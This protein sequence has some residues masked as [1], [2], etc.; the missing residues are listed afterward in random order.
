ME[1]IENYYK[2]PTKITLSQAFQSKV[3]KIYE[4]MGPT[5]NFQNQ[6]E[7]TLYNN[8]PIPLIII[9][10]DNNGN[11]SL[12]DPIL[13][14]KTSGSHIKGLQNAAK[15][16]LCISASAA[17]IE[18]MWSKGGKIITQERSNLS[19]NCV[20]SLLY[21]IGNSDLLPVIANKLGYPIFK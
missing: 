6:T 3:L 16:Y 13:W 19:C 20:S 21:V 12:N 1:F 9:F 14:W 2:I 18:R 11:Y 7:F 10:H 4:F 5:Q 8:L 15:D 17:N